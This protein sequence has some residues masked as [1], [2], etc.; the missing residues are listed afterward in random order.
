MADSGRFSK[1][2]RF[3]VPGACKK[4]M[5]DKKK[6]QPRGKRPGARAPAVGS[7]RP[8]ARFCMLC[9]GRMRPIQEHGVRRRA[10]ERCGFI[11]YRNPV[12]AC[13][14]LIQREGT[15]LLARRGLE[16]RKNA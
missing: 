8:E 16:H 13:G 12:P 9:G 11:A 6:G 10:C 3:F 15:I 2:G 14:V 1:D 5:R 7:T 4:T